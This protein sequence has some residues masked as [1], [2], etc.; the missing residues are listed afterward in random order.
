MELTSTKYK[1]TGVGLIPEDWEVRALGD[2]SRI[3]MGQSPSSTNYNTNG[4]GLPLVQGNA[5]IKDRKTI[6]R[7][8]CCPIKK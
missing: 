1:E 7:N 6:I 5:D 8:H 4:I 2:I 3:N